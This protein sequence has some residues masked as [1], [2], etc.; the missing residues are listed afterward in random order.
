MV[1]MISIANLYATPKAFALLPFVLVFNIGGGMRALGISHPGA[2]AMTLGSKRQRIGGIPFAGALFLALRIIR[3]GIMTLSVLACLLDNALSVFFVPRAIVLTPTLFVGGLPSALPLSVRFSIGTIVFAL[4]L[5]QT[6]PIR[7][8]IGAAFFSLAL[9]VCPSP[10]QSVEFFDPFR[11]S[12]GILAFL[13]GKFFLV[14]NLVSAFIFR[15]VF[16]IG[17]GIL[18][19]THFADFAQSTL[20]FFRA[21]EIRRGRGLGFAAF[22]TGLLGR[23][24][25]LEG[26]RNLSFR[27]QAQG[28]SRGVAWVHLLGLI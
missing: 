4:L 3:V 19:A 17:N 9:L 20:T 5:L 6:L 28:R 11:M 23:Y 15:D 26:H 24:G 18:S 16:A 27:C 7:L 25:I 22:S 1:N 10:S 8:T 13:V 21:M 12:S 2:A 14:C